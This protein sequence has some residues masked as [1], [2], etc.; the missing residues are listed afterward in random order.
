MRVQPAASRGDRESSSQRREF[1]N[2][3]KDWASR[4]DLEM[5]SKRKSCKP[6]GRG[7]RRRTEVV[8]PARFERA[9]CRG[10]TASTGASFFPVC[11]STRRPC[12]AGTRPRCSG[13]RNTITAVRWKRRRP[14]R[15]NTRTC[16]ETHDRSRRR[17]CRRYCG[18]TGRGHRARPPV[19]SPS[20]LRTAAPSLTIC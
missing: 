20:S 18:A 11:G 10:K 8:S 19:P 7:V 2:H 17:R 6:K 13:R 9:T 12:S 16:R 14:R 15:R 5:R 3:C 4:A 1:A